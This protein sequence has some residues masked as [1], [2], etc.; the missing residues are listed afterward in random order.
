MLRVVKSFSLY[1]ICLRLLGL[2]YIAITLLDSTFQ[3]RIPSLN[4]M[5]CKI[6]QVAQ[7]ESKKPFSKMPRKD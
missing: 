6:R 4:F 1:R 2:A 3:L 7:E 5:L